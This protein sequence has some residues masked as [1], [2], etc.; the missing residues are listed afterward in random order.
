MFTGLVSDLGR[1]LGSEGM[2]DKRFRIA[3]SYPLGEVAIGASIACNGCCLSVVEKGEGWFAVDVSGE[4][5]SK[6]TL[7]DWQ[8]D[9]RVNLERA[10]RL[11]DELG[12][13]LVSGHV[14][15]IAEILE[16][17]PEGGSLRFSLRAPGHLARYIAPKGSVTLDG[18]SLT[19]N[20]VEGAEFGVN[21]IPHTAQVTTFGRY[22]A[23]NRVNLEIDLLARYV[24]RLM[25]QQD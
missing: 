20:E 23:G 14:D 11:G 1:L 21:I 22:E 6:T 7:G 13:H 25:A 9:H 10:L 17:R 4:T 2:E 19:V 8:P 16:I 5:L 24:A 18:V 12:G 15:G 3:T